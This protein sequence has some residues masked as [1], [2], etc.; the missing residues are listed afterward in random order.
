MITA[1][2]TGGKP[3]VLTDTGVFAGADSEVRREIQRQ[4]LFWK[5]D[6]HSMY[7]NPLGIL[8]ENGHMACFAEAGAWAL[9][10]PD[11]RVLWNL[12]YV[13]QCRFTTTMQPEECPGF[14]DWLHNGHFIFSNPWG[15]E[16]ESGSSL[17]YIDACSYVQDM[18][19]MASVMGEWPPDDDSAACKAEFPSP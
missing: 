6:G 2:E 15:V 12:A 17:D 4:F 11:F 9:S 7:T 19:W 14:L 16:Y 5:G 18:A 3:P 10:Q 1:L 13:K 8:D